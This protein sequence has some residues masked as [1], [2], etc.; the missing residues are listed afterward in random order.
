MIGLD[1][2][3]GSCNSVDDLSTKICVPNKTKNMTVRVLN[4]ITNENEAKAMIKHISCGFKCK[5]NSTTYSSNRKWNNEI[6]QC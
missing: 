2:C 5:L 4:M 3:N 6:C 1:K